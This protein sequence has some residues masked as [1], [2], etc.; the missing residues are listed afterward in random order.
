MIVKS[1][2]MLITCTITPN[3]FYFESPNFHLGG[4]FKSF[5]SYFVMGQNQSGPLQNKRNS[6]LGCTQNQLINRIHDI[7]VLRSLLGLCKFSLNK[8]PKVWRRGSLLARTQK[9]DDNLGRNISYSQL[10]SLTSNWEG[11]AF[12]VLGAILSP[13]NPVQLLTL[14]LALWRKRRSLFIIENLASEFA[15]HSS[16]LWPICSCFLP[17]TDRKNNKW[18]KVPPKVVVVDSSSSSSS[19]RIE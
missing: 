1:V 12:S 15:H 18:T 19:L 9:S 4:L 6:T 5:R 11:L 17:R 7:W 3:W 14:H 13:S 10:D 2:V 8:V 16:S